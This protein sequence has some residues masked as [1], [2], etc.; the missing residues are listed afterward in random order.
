[1]DNNRAV[2]EYSVVETAEGPE[3]WRFRLK[4]P[5]GQSLIESART[6]ASQA[7]AEEGFIAMIRLI[8]ANQYTIRCP[9]FANAE[10]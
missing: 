3:S 7:K 6:F 9:E 4:S 2:L 1:M 8:A 10:E 5:D